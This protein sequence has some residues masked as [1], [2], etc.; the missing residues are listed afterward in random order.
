MQQKSAGLS[1]CTGAASALVR[2]WQLLLLLTNIYGDDTIFLY[3]GAKQNPAPTFF[4]GH[5]LGQQV[6]ETQGG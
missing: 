2:Q 1:R 3:F 6:D 4:A 5:L